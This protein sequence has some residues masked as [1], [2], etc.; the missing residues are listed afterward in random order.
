MGYMSS[1]ITASIII[2]AWNEENIIQK[3]LGHLEEIHVNVPTE[4]I[5]IA[6]GED[7]TIRVCSEWTNRCHIKFE[8]CICLHQDIGDGKIG[9]L[10]KGL[11]KCRGRY[12]LLLDADTIVPT[13]W[14]EQVLEELQTYDAISCNYEPINLNTITSGQV[15][16][17]KWSAIA[18]GQRFLRGGASIGIRW[19]ALND[20][21][22]G[23]IFPSG[24]DIPADDIYLNWALNHHDKDIGPIITDVTVKTQ[25]P[26]NLLQLYRSKVRWNSV[27]YD[28]SKENRKRILRTLVYRGFVS[29]APLNLL[30][31]ISLLVLSNNSDIFFIILLGAFPSIVFFLNFL[32]YRILKVKTASMEKR[33]AWFWLPQFL[34]IEYIVSLAITSVYIQRFLGKESKIKQFREAR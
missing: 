19:E 33:E 17:N 4:V 24:K 21:G 5:L 3:T 14:L 30:F 12:V 29:I 32:I 26:R 18:N 6:G 13:N 34:F 8:T 1:N 20:I 28:L 22:V 2:P 10:K 27:R 7:E 11:K 15:L 16:I 31:L 23:N 25:F 9:A